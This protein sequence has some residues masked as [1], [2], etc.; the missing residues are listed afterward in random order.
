[1]TNGQEPRSVLAKLS[2]EELGNALLAGTVGE[3]RL[4]RA[5]VGLLVAHGHWLARRELRQAVETHETQ[6]GDVM[7]WVVWKRVDLGGMAAALGDVCLLTLACSLGGVGSDR[8][9]AELLSSLDSTNCARVLNAIAVACTGRTVAR[10]RDLW[11]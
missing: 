3:G 9:L 7:A 2:D 6:D 8:S 1:M 10:G 11:W 5:A 4:E